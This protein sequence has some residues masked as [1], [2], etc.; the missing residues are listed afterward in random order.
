MGFN[1]NFGQ[2]V[3]SNAQKD[4]QLDLEQQ[5]INNQREAQA[6]SAANQAAASF[7]T[8]VIAKE[9]IALREKEL[10]LREQKQEHD[11]SWDD[12]LKQQEI[13]EREA[14]I[15]NLRKISEKYDAAYE[16]DKAQAE[17]MAN[18]AKRRQE[19]LNGERGSLF[20]SAYTH[21]GRVSPSQIKAFNEATGAQY[22]FIGNTMSIPMSD[23]SVRHETIGDGKGFFMG[24]FQRDEKGNVIFGDDG[25]PMTQ[26]VE[27]PKEMRNALLS[28]AYGK[29][30]VNGDRT[31]VHG[32]GLEIAKIN[33]EQKEKDR[34]AKTAKS[35]REMAFKEKKFE[36]GVSKDMAKEAK[37]FFSSLNDKDK[38]MFAKKYPQMA[39]SILGLANG[40]EEP[41]EEEPTGDNE[42][43]ELSREEFAKL[44]DE[45]KKA[46]K[47]RWMA[48]K[49]SQAK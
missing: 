29:A 42:F 17:E 37:D 11:L 45:E 39:K 21:G 28:S 12:A 35:D 2:A 9:A 46:Y 15:G 31:G 48:W 34:A 5:R 16:S 23:G 43:V 49:Q 14:R 33:A 30:Y 24:Q 10:Y 47:E 4:R 25:T 18:H 22:D 38:E 1:I 6:A 26:M 44:S 7:I 32:D 40:S 13:A 3:I 8:R 19:L 27:M 36:Y 41:S 20:L